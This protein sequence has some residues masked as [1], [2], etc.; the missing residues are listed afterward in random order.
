[1]S[2]I[3]MNGAKH[4]ITL[5]GEEFP[6]SHPNFMK[7]QQR[8]LRQKVVNLWCLEHGHEPMFPHAIDD[9]AGEQAE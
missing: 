2:T 4:H 9:S 3:R 6:L 8:E 5:N 1:M 7:G